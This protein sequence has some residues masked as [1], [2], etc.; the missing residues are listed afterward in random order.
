MLNGL[1]AGFLGTN[2]NHILD[3][4]HENFPIADF[5]GFGGFDDGIDGGGDLVISEH[6]FD[7]DFREKIDC[8]FAAA[9][10]FGVSLL[11]SETLDLADRHAFHANL[12]QRFFH[13]FK[14]ERF[15]DRLDFLHGYG[16]VRDG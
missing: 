2:P 16:F 12:A 3:C 7:F 11:P 1:F 9:V 14:L 4:A 6:D 5:A 15:D 8:V 13:L 10:D